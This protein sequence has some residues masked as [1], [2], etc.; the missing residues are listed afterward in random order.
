[1]QEDKIMKMVACMESQDFSFGIL[2]SDGK[3]EFAPVEP[4]LDFQVDSVFGMLSAK[5][6]WQELLC[7]G[8]YPSGG[9]DAALVRRSLMEE[10]QW[11]RPC[12]LDGKPLQYVMWVHLLRQ[13]AQSESGD[14]GIIGDQF[15]EYT[16]APFVA[17]DLLWNQMEWFAV[18]KEYGQELPEK[19]HR[20]ACHNLCRLREAFV[21]MKD[22][23]SP[24]LWQ[25][26]EIAVENMQ[27]ELSQ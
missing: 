12:F 7:V 6:L 5:S 4:H 13:L 18:L 22:A 16:G 15:C 10:C 25:Q 1:M 26:Y 24:E 11:L 8:K 21:P 17:E 2:F 14:V 20:R 27:K 3:E 19:N 9:L 23:V